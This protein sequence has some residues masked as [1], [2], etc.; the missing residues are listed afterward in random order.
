MTMGWMETIHFIGLDLQVATV[1]AVASLDLAAH[2]LKSAWGR[3][4]S[5]APSRGSVLAREIFVK[6][7]A[8]S[9]ATESSTQEARLRRV[10]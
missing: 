7:P 1:L 5:R 10:A 2:A 8:G 6:P 3:I 4:P 9:W